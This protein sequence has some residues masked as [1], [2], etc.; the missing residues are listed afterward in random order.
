MRE[1]QCFRL[2]MTAVI[3]IWCLSGLLIT[4]QARATTDPWLSWRHDLQNTAAVPDR[5]YPTS[6]K[7]PLWDHPRGNEAGTTMRARCS[8]PVVV[9]NDI[10]FTTGNGGV[11]EALDQK[12][13]ELIWTK[14]YTW[15]PHRP[16]Q[17]MRSRTGARVL[18]PIS[19]P[20]W[21]SAPT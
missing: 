1:R 13:G 5:G 12:T 16:N 17:R 19:R 21:A 6:V 10:V 7:E 2:L 14:T 4:T 18:P 3:F 20:T 15:I 8:T 11:V 9:G